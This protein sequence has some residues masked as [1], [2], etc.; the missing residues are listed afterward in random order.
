[1]V[2]VCWLGVLVLAGNGF[3]IRI[4]KRKVVSLQLVPSFC[5]VKTFL[6]IHKMA[7]VSD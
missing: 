7:V 4:G 3:L 5:A 2:W 6:Q 1:M